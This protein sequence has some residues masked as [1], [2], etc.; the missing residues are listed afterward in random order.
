M[1]LKYS[2]SSWTWLLLFLLLLAPSSAWAEDSKSAATVEKADKG[3]ISLFDGETLKNWKSTAFGSEGEVSV[4]DGCLRLDKGKPM[5]GITWTGEALPKVNYEITWEARRVDGS[6][7]YCALTFPVKEDPCTFVV[8]GWG[9]KLC[10]LSSINYQDAS[11]NE[12]TRF[13]EFEQGKWYKFKLRVT[14]KKIETWLDEKSLADVDYTDKKLTIRLEV[15]RSKPLG[16]S[17]YRTLGEIRKVQ[18]KKLTATPE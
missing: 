12:T 7:F 6:D 13:Q 11:E 4:K 8:G 18:L 16:F 2:Q 14:E 5:T 1:T 17:T 10:G 15:E 3:V 9:G